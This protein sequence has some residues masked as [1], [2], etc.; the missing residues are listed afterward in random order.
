MTP[1]DRARL[2]ARRLYPRS[3][4]YQ[5][6]YVKGA[7]AAVGGGQESACP[8]KP[9]PLKTWARAYR[10]AWLRGFRSVSGTDG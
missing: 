7:R 1:L 4:S 2:R 9:D 6:V 5:S 3:K 10:T 8:Y